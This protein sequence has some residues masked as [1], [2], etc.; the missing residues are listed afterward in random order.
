MSGD[1]CLL[2]AECEMH[3]DVMKAIVAYSNGSRRRLAD[4]AARL[5]RAVRRGP[6]HHISMSFTS[7][8]KKHILAVHVQ[9]CL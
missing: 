5:V 6:C 1:A 7:N 8:K 3:A 9:Q 2:D 4:D